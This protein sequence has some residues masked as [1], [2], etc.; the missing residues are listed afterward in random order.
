MSGKNKNYNKLIFLTTLSVYLGLVLV[1]GSPQVFAYAA[2]TRNFD[3]QQEIEFKDDLDNKPDEDLKVTSDAIDNYFS[4][5]KYFIEDLQKLH[6]IEK[7]DLDYDEFRIKQVGF[8][9][10]DVN[11]DPAQRIEALKKVDN[12]WIEAAIIDATY[13]A[14]HWNY[15][16]DCLPS[17]KF[18]KNRVTSSGLEINYDKSAL[19]FTIS[20]DKDSPQKAKQ[21]SET[22]NQ[23][24]KVYVPDNDEIIVKKISENTSFTFENNQVFI[25]TRLPRAGLDSLT[26]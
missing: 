23:A 7:F 1:S 6:K 5:L 16:S 19:K 11:G 18:G 22:F 25:V 3:I 2:T 13:K 12:K 26:K 14:E 15:L 17:N 21:L 4:D 20:V 8:V 24:F 9:P 10:C